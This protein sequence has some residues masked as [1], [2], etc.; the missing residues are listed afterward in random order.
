MHLEA[1]NTKSKEIASTKAYTIGRRGS[2][3]DYL[4]LYFIISLH[5]ISLSEIIEL[6]GKKYQDNFNAR[7][8]LEQLVYLDDVDDAEIIFLQDKVERSTV[9]MFFENE[10]KKIELF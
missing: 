9:S 4:D 7:L 2:Y 10:I 1:L 5:Y 3:K 8:F 6:A